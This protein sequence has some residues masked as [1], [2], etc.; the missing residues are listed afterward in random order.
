M[1]V[2]Y[3][4]IDME[5]LDHSRFKHW[6]FSQDFCITCGFCASFCPVSGV[7]D[8]NPRMLIRMIALGMQQDV[9]EARW[10]WICTLCARCEYACPMEIDIADVVRNTRFLRD[11]D[12]VPG[13]LHKGLQAAI[14]TGNN[15][16]LPKEDYE[17]II[18]EFF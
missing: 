7:D 2:Q 5:S 8:F 13:I 6:P 18:T 10:P 12:K 9:R 16:R 4:R 11:R 15:L 17:F 3:D 1:T 14:D